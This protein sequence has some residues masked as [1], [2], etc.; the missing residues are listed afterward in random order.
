MQK[1]VV[2]DNA[3]I[4]AEKNRLKIIGGIIL[5]VIIMIIAPIAVLLGVIDAG[6]Q[7]DWNSP[8]LQQAFPS[9]PHGRRAQDIAGDQSPRGNSICGEN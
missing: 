7:I 2:T 8:E 9:R 1:Y 5:G 3:A 6:A 4:Y